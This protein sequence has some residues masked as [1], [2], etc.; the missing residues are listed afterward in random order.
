MAPIAAP[1]ELDALNQS[2]HFLRGVSTRASLCLPAFHFFVGSIG[3]PLNDRGENSQSTLVSASYME[4]SCLN[5]MTLVCRKVF[6]HSISGL[7]GAKFSK[8]ADDVLTRHAALWAGWSGRSSEDAV[9]ALR[10]L[11]SFFAVCSKHTNVLLRSPTALQKRIGLLKQHAD[12]SAAHLSLDSYEIDLLDLAH[13]VA[14]ICLVGEIIRGFDACHLGE[15]YFQQVDRA[16]ADEA[17]RLFPLSKSSP[18][19][20]HVEPV[21]QARSCWRYGENLGFE[22][23]LEQLPYAISWF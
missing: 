2:I 8:T 17:K 23:L 11:R 6:D 1:A 13:F 7:T 18:L 5:T 19:F 9:T 21:S 12:R 4:F 15:S 20:E 3:K 22:M 10:F 16:A 14:S